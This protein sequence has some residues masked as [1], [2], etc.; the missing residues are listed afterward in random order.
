[1]DELRLRQAFKD[2]HE[3]VIQRLIR[4]GRVSLQSPDSRNTWTTLFYALRYGMNDLVA[5]LLEHGHD[6]AGISVDMRGNTA[7]CVALEHGNLTGFDM[8]LHRHP[9]AADRANTRGITPLMMAAQR[10]LNA[11][12]NVRFVHI[13]DMGG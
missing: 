1:M 13:Y 6:A 10:G 3:L 8:Y 9:E 2:G 5:F 11:Q 12:I 4:S 7:L